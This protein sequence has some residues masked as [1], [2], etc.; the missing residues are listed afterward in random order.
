MARFKKSENLALRTLGPEQIRQVRRASLAVHT[1]AMN[2]GP[3]WELLFHLSCNRNFIVTPLNGARFL[4]LILD[5][6]HANG[7]LLYK[8]SAPTSFKA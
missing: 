1:Y 4:Q 5:N 3:I 8:M 2:S 6:I 7:Y